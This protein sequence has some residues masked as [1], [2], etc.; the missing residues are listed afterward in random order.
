MQ[1]TIISPQPTTVHH[2]EIAIF[3]LSLI[4]DLLFLAVLSKIND[5]IKTIAPKIRISII[6]FTHVISY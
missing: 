5:K 4:F 2:D 6:K 1:N 3:N